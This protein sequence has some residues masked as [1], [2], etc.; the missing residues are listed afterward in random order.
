M[1]RRFPSRQNPELKSGGSQLVGWKLAIRC[2]NSVGV[3]SSHVQVK[4]TN[5]QD[6]LLLP[7]GKAMGIIGCRFW[8]L[9]LK[10]K[11]EPQLT[12]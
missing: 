12:M 3:H 1:T 11:Y 9:E 4:E 10:C 8:I 6:R 5:S 7:V 2:C